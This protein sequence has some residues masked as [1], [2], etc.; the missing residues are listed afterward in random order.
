MPDI[1]HERLIV[2]L[3]FL[4]PIVLRFTEAP[5]LLTVWDVSMSEDGR[6][7]T[8]LVSKSGLTK[9]SEILSDV[10]A[11]TALSFSSK[12]AGTCWHSIIF[13]HKY[14]FC[15]NKSLLRQNTHICCN[16]HNFVLTSFV[17]TSILFF[18]TNRCFSWQNTNICHDKSMLVAI[19]LLSWQNYVCHDKY[20]SQQMFC[21][22][23]C[24]VVTK[25]L[26]W[27]SYFCHNKQ[28]VLSWQTHVCHDK[29]MTCCVMTNTCLSQQTCVCCNKTFVVTK[30]ILVAAPT[31]DSF[32]THILI[33][34]MHESETP[35]G[36]SCKV[37]CWYSL[38]L[39]N[40]LCL[41]LY[42][43]GWY[44]MST[45]TPYIRCTVI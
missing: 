32:H 39:I 35:W 5:F 24:F 8:I 34:S 25:V 31:N 41:Q 37:L 45:S 22:D 43:H 16:K 21:C 18:A 44:S 7:S 3:V 12:S 11:W 17:V 40:L 15:H 28:P 2:K 10:K 23:K 27:P 4:C 30:M 26:L 20:L 6:T 38:C 33:V 14:Y 9:S 36:I 42:L 13:Y 19:K 29:Q 1:V